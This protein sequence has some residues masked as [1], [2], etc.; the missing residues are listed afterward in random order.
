[1]E[2]CQLQINYLDWNF[3]KAKE[4]VELLESYH[5]PVWVMGTTPGAAGC[6]SLNEEDTARLHALRPEETVPGWAFRFLQ[7]IPGVT[8]TLSGMSTLSGSWRK[9]SGPSPQ[10]SL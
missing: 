3:Q 6:T 9:I 7:S 1:M 2:F 8:V 5:I 10:R 4:N